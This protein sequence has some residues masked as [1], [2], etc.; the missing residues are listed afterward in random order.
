MFGALA[1]IKLFCKDFTLD[2]TINQISKKIKKSY[3]YTNK[4]VREFIHK[5]ILNKKIVGPSIL[6]SLNLKNDLTIALLVLCSAE[7]KQE[8]FADKEDLKK[9]LDALVFHIKQNVDCVMY[10]DKHIHIISRDHVDLPPTEFSIGV[11]GLD[12]DPSGF[13]DCVILYGFENFWRLV[14]DRR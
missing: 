6:C 11:L 9:K 2:Y 10:K 7:K 1:I 14:G 4:E 5:G 3:A 13:A 8:F 12:E